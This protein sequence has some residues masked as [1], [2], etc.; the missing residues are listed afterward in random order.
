[1]AQDS[2]QLKKRKRILLGILVAFI[3]AYFIVSLLFIVTK[4]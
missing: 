2:D 4:Q 1:M 3:I